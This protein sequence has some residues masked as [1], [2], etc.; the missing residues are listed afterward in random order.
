MISTNTV[1]SWF[2][3]V[4]V[5]DWG[6]PHVVWN[7][8]RPKGQEIMDLLMYSTL[9]DSGWLEPGDVAVTAYGGY[10]V[11]PAV[12]VDKA[13]TLHVT[14]RGETTIYYTSAPISEARKASSWTPRRRISG[15]GNDTAYYSDV[16][17][18]EQGMIHVVWNEGESADVGERWVWFGTPQGAAL[19]DGKGWRIQE[20]QA[21]LGN[22]VIY[23]MI[24][25]AAG[26][27]WF[28]TDEGVYRFDGVTWQTLTTQDGLAGQ[29]VYCLVQDPDGRLWFGTDGGVSLYDEEDRRT[30]WINYTVLSGL[31]DNAVHAI[32]ID[33]LGVVWAGT[34][35]GVASYDGERWVRYADQ[36][37]L[38]A[39]AVNAVAVD[40]QWNVWVGTGQGV[41]QYDGQ[42]WTTYTVENGLVGN[43]VTAI[44]VDQEDVMWFGTDNGVSRFNGREWTSYTPGGG[45]VG[46]AVTALLVDGEGILWAGTD[47]GV[48]RYDGRA[49][50]T[51]TLPPGFSGQKVTAITEDRRVNAMCPSC[52]DI[53][54]RHST[55]GGKTWSAAVNLSSSFAGSAKP[56]IHVGSGGKVYV[57]WEEGE[58]WYLYEGYPVASM[59]T[60]SADGGHTWNKPI[61]FT[62]PWGAPQ[63]MALG[64]GQEGSL[65]VVWRVP[66]AD[67]FYYQISTDDGTT[68]SQPAPIPGVL[69]NVWAPFSLDACDATTDS[70]GTVHFLVLGHRFSLEEDLGVFHLVWDGST[71]SSPVRVFASSDPP[72]W[73]RI[74]IGAGNQVYATWFTR[75]QKHI[76]DPD[77]GRYKIW[78]S[79][80]E[81]S[82]P[83]QTPFP[84]PVVA[85]TA[86]SGTPEQAKPTP[87]A[88]PVSII[89]PADSG[90][91]PGLDTESDEIGRLALALSPTII[92][93]LAIVVLRLRKPRYRR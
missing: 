50:E 59:Y 48:S 11:R 88:T 31:P 40:A 49:W 13:G 1:S 84:S 57:T 37:G 65:V 75:D 77:H 12:A 45:L 82:A 58:D 25:D 70:A 47:A 16:A 44:T 62:S 20:P 36:D 35:K 93:L 85:S 14:F 46:G 78:V 32:A 76:E 67:S 71:W 54:Y 9:T 4:V 19:Y 87:T 27:Q 68:W 79:F 61:A 90:L 86:E 8:G 39:A 21:G 5:D 53:F 42:R 10:T 73:P 89:V 74:E 81:A 23:A 60:Y 3:D 92:V 2:P 28:G 91:P 63:Q 69:T 38:A 43:V 66:E 22:R 29:Q 56:Q 83:P 33:P 41:S 15:A 24:E 52:A 18:D 34:E 30:P 6:R 7:S 26:A 72:E 51:V 55:D 80:Y 17:V 64:I